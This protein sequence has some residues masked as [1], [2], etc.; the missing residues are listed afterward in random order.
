MIYSYG[1]TNTAYL[2]RVTR[3]PLVV[4]VSLCV[5]YDQVVCGLGAE[6]NLHCYRVVASISDHLTVWPFC[7]CSYQ[8]YMVA[9][10]DKKSTHKLEV[11]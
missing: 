8:V 5:V 9:L 4:L 7:T 3:A 6:D 2:A 10:Y 1:V 11:L